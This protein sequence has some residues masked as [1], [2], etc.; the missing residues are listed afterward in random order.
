M[1]AGITKEIWKKFAPSHN[2]FLKYEFFEALAL[3]GCIGPNAGWEPLVLVNESEDVAIYSFI[4]N[5]SYGEYI[6][7]WAWAEAYQKYN[8]PYYPKL[9]SMLPFTPATTEHFLMKSFDKDKAHL[10]LEK[11]EAIYEKNELSSIHFLFLA[12]HEISFFEE[13]G[14]IIRESLQYHF[15][16][17][18]YKNFD[19][20]LT[21]LK[22]RKAKQI[23]N[24]RR[25]ENLEIKQYTRDELTEQEAKR[26]YQFY[27]ST[28]EVKHSHDYL[29]EDFFKRIFHS[30][31]ENIL[32]VEASHE[33]K[34]VAGSLFFYDS[35]TLYGRYWGASDFFEKLH[36]EL[37]YYQGIEFCLKNNL[38][39]FEAGAQGEHKISR[40]FTPTRIFSAHKIKHPAF[41][42]AIHEH[43]KRE[44]ASL[45]SIIS[46]LSQSLP[47]RA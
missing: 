45:T 47:F 33:G 42:E 41:R 5:H 11:L 38:K 40:G 2:P 4:K 18:G 3:S 7:D 8:V 44:K 12:P 13:A 43:I 26:M 27:I 19:H 39:R 17:Q 32:Y 29:N 31:K 35:E 16:N 36:F 14:Y 46:E 34:A 6:F 23:R 24:E 30:M 25:H 37:C 28:I 21:H 1:I 15:F 9:T 22:S 10:L 20:Y